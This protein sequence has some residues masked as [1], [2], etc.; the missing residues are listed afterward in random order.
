M[1]VAVSPS[2][3]IQ[4][5]IF[6]LR[7]S[8]LLPPLTDEEY[9]NLKADIA[10]HGIT[11][12]VVVEHQINHIY[13]VIDGQHRLKIA[14]ELGLTID[15]IPLKIETY[16][17]DDEREDAAWGLNAHRRHMTKEQR[18][19]YALRLRQRG[20]SYRDIGERLKV[21]KSTAQRDVEA[22]SG[23]PF[24]TPE[25]ADTGIDVRNLTPE[26]VGAGT[27]EASEP[28][29][30]V[31]NATPNAGETSAGATNVAGESDPDPR[32][33]APLPT[34]I[35]GRDGKS[36]PA[37]RPAPP[38]APPSVSESAKAR[39]AAFAADSVAA[40]NRAMWEGTPRSFYQGGPAW[41]PF[42]LQTHENWKRDEGVPPLNLWT[43]GKC[44]RRVPDRNMRPQ[45]TTPPAAPD[46]TPTPSAPAEAPARPAMASRRHIVFTHKNAAMQ[47]KQHPNPLYR[48][49]SFEWY[50]PSF[51]L[52][53]AR[54][55]LGSFD[56]DPASSALANETVQAARFF[57]KDINGLIQ[58][59][60]NPD[61]SPAKVWLNPPFGRYIIANW[62]DKLL[63]EYDAGHVTEC[64]LL[65]AARTETAWLNKLYSFPRCFIQKRVKF[66]PGP[67]NTG[68]SDSAGFPS[69]ALYLGPN[70]DGF[71]AHFANLGD[72]YA[73]LQ[74]FKG[75]GN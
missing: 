13:D 6:I 72:V 70:V 8:H 3:K 16:A 28:Q 33:A 29:P 71:T 12:P 36:Y 48:N 23:V 64:I 5:A 57:D 63:V 20:L 42:C 60:C 47:P 55:V 69:V 58:D 7:Y 56:L 18:Q 46:K 11:L 21:G 22:M 50:T 74:P 51:L 65:V 75:R 35:T 10:A 67:G 44:G 27:S 39:S 25:D 52:D 38:P 62:V 68:K 53:C 37:V 49:K 14:A 15:Q 4:H 54:L 34:T 2:I 59:W 17:S 66:I 61:G 31:A 1:D 40:L 73:L 19:A 45:S 43:C 24:G 9:A 41:C 32:A 30:R 26:V